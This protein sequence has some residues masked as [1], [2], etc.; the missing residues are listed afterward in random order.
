MKKA[1][2]K[3]YI[4]GMISFL[5]VPV[6]FYYY[7][8]K[9]HDEIH[10]FTTGIRILNNL[11][12]SKDSICHETHMWNCH[13]IVNYSPISFDGKND[14]L[15]VELA[16]KLISK[17]YFHKDSITIHFTFGKN[18]TYNTFIKTLNLMYVNKV[19]RYIL[20]NNDFVA[21]IN[22]KDVEPKEQTRQIICGFDYEIYKHKQILKHK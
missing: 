15:N 17:C 19:S 9:K 13:K 20:N 10:Q 6:L 12:I 7:G 1:F 3:Y 11:T 2:Q 21:I 18:A 4:T 14:L 22:Y 8:N 5:I 16:Q